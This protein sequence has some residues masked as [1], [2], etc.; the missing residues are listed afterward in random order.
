MESMTYQDIKPRP[1]CP[2]LTYNPVK[3]QWTHVR[4]SLSIFGIF[5]KSAVVNDVREEMFSSLTAQLQEVVDMNVSSATVRHF[6]VPHQLVPITVV[7][8]DS[9]SAEQEE[10]TKSKR[11]DLHA[12]FGLPLNRPFFRPTN[13]HLTT[14]TGPYL[15]NP[16]EGLPQLSTTGET[17]MVVG[18]YAY[19]HYMQDRFDD[20]GWGCAYRSLQT[21]CSWFRFQGYT[22]GSVPAHREIQEA[23]VAAGDKEASLVGSKQWIGSFEVSI[24]L[25]HFCGVTSKILNVTSGREMGGIGRQLLKHFQEE[26]TPVM[27]GGG[28]LAHTILGV[29]YSQT[30]GDIQFLIL[31]P[32]YTAGEDL[33][34]ILNKGWCSWKKVEFWDQQ[35]YYNLCMPQ[36]PRE[37]I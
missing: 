30:T 9:P 4:Y 6:P 31:D 15:L 13:L 3:T 27:I 1:F 23:L 29:H 36:R 35:A 11:L 14:D 26:G 8:P 16:H 21:L 28:L 19:H 12:M 33:K 37:M 10:A 18:W 24:C 2:I 5:P 22:D 32:H 25:N 34:T 20:N 17:A 7:C